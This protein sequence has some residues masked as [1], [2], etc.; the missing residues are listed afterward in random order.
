VGMLVAAENLAYLRS[1]DTRVY[2]IVVYVV[3]QR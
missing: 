1:Q 3:F 2:L